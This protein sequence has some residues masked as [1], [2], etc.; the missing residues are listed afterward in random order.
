M[1]R[2]DP[3]ESESVRF[4]SISSVST[5]RHV[6]AQ[7]ESDFIRKVERT[8]NLNHPEIML[9]NNFTGQVVMAVGLKKDGSIYSIQIRKSSGYPALDKSATKIVR[10]S[11]PFPPIPNVLL[12][13]RDVYIVTKS[14]SFSNESGMTAN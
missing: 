2:N 3:S 9:E 13:E 5:H 10:M 1:A 14:W 12:N 4:K 6:A 8:G 11:A 7:Y